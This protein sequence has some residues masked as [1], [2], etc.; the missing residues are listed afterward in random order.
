MITIKKL[1]FRYYKG[2][3]NV[4]ND[5]SIDIKDGTINVL[6]GLNGCG[7]T[8]LIKLLAGLLNPTSGE[9][10]YNEKLLKNISM[11]DRSRIFSY[12]SQK[13]VSNDDYIVRDYLAYG[14]ANSLKF[15]E[16]PKPKQL[17]KINEISQR[18]NIEHLLD[19]KIGRLSGGE[20]QII[21]IASALVQN[22]PIIL[23]DEPT[24]A[25]DLKNQNLVLSLLDEIAKEG[26][27]IIISTHN[28]NHA[29]FLNA[30]I[31]FMKEGRIIKEGLCND[32]LDMYTLQKIYGD[33]ICFS[34]EL[35]YKEVSFKHRV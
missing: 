16:S 33:S 29:L 17:I 25:L 10:L 28:P 9:I 30:N 24:S 13:S 4:I 21:I 14:F 8:T 18:L 6:V 5:L 12:V 31:L 19:K 26:K 27:I 2:L 7:K 3:K 22:T 35:P 32:I 20:R 23:L 11:R 1:S 15:Y 34:N